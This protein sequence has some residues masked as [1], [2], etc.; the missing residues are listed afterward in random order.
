M[1]YRESQALRD[2][3]NPGKQENDLAELRPGMI[4]KS[5]TGHDR[6][7]IYLVM[8][9]A[10]DRVWLTDGRYRPVS[11]P[12]KKNLRHVKIFDRTIHKDDLAKLQMLQDHGQQ[13]ACIRKI[14]SVYE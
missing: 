14:L 9:V 11:R 3:D 2:I 12:K 4:V 6:G 5:K 1:Q 13:N 10:E 8:C 7:R